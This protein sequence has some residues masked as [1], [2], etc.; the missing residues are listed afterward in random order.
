M[1]TAPTAPAAVPLLERELGRCRRSSH[2]RR[3][4]S[5]LFGGSGPAYLV[6]KACKIAVYSTGC[7]GY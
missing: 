2:R 1:D 6:E 3:H 5:T 4:R 7:Q